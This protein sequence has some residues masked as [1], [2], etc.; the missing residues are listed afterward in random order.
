[1]DGVCPFRGGAPL[2]V[3]H[4]N[5]HTVSVSMSVFSLS[6][7][8]LRSQGSLLKQCTAYTPTVVIHDP[9]PVSKGTQ[10]RD[11]QGHQQ[12]PRPPHCAEGECWKA[13]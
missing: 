2:F 12:Q 8:Y 9:V 3:L 1:M 11:K 5:I 10:V 4:S 6:L 7:E 13:A